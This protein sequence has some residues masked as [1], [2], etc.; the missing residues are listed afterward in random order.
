MFASPNSQHSLGSQLGLTH[1]SLNMPSIILFVVLAFFPHQ[2]IGLDCPP[3]TVFP[4]LRQ[5]PLNGESILALAVLCHFMRSVPATFLAENQ[6]C[7]MN[8]YHV[9]RRIAVQKGEA[10]PE[11]EALIIYFLIGIKIEVSTE[12]SKHK[13]DHFSYKVLIMKK[14]GSKYNPNLFICFRNIK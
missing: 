10:E 8:V 3:A 9:C 14:N 11:T 4:V 1:A 2:K 12:S 7:F 13:R 6:A 5:P